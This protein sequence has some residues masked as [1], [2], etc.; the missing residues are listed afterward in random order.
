MTSFTRWRGVAPQRTF[1]SLTDLAVGYGWTVWLRGS[2]AKWGHG[3]DL[4]VMFLPAWLNAIEPWQMAAVVAGQREWT[5]VQ[6]AKW[7]ITHRYV[8]IVVAD[9]H[10]RLVDALFWRL[11]HDD[12]HVQ[13]LA[14]ARLDDAIGE[15]YGDGC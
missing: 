9:T 7:D 14:E 3:R 1:R 2:V 8:Q 13:T 12:P 15:G 5:I 4:D 10:N 6:P 11:P